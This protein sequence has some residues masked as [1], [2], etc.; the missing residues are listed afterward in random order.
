MSEVTIKPEQYTALAEEVSKLKDTIAVLEASL[1][2]RDEQVKT[3]TRQL[4]AQAPEAIYSVTYKVQR[5]G[6][7]KLVTIRAR[8]G[9]DWERFAFRD[10]AV[11]E[12]L[13]AEG[14][15]P[16]ESRVMPAR[17]PET[18]VAHAAPAVAAPAPASAKSFEGG[19]LAATVD[20]GKTRWR[21]KGGPWQR[22]GIV[23]YDEV[24]VAAGLVGLNPLQPVDLA[25]WT[26]YYSENDEGKPM[27]VTR[28]VAPQ[29]G[30]R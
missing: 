28:L 16:A 23:V 15:V 6:F 20:G 14:W 5:R 19:V 22:F 29:K 11:E 26:V 24:L 1:A 21:V 30:A 7:E 10:Q 9:E 17:S 27:K 25:G 13:V 4:D 8:P 2:T 18:V 3:L 12:H